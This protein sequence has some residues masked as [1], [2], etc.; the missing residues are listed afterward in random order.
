[1]FAETAASVRFRWLAIA[2]CAT[3]YALVVLGGVVRV[4]DSGDACPDWPRCHGELLPPLETDVLIEFSHRLLASVVG[5]LVVALAIA[6]WRTQRGPVVR[7][8]SLL[9]VGLVVVQIVLGGITVLSD[10]S[11]NMVMAHLAVA[12]AFFATLLVVALFSF[13]NPVRSAATGDMARFRTQAALASLA[14]LALMLTGSYVS[15]SG[16]GLAFR[17]WPLFDGGLLPDGAR[18]AV[19]HYAHRLAALLVGLYL[20]HVAVRA[21]RRHREQR[22]V[23]VLSTVIVALYGAQ[24]LV[25]AANIWTLLQPA[26]AGAHLALAVL[27][28]G[29]L[30]SMTV[31]AHRAALP[32]PAAAAQPARP[33]VEPARAAALAEPA[34]GQS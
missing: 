5:L 20:I 29:L 33:A 32:A 1:M 3:T 34:R 23:V 14:T 8:G 9:A 15:G 31:I 16:A 17:D 7:W 27:V 22:A 11:A 19:I 30:V 13:P 18:L 12:S 4:T 10:L 2:T 26:A 24:A 6:A 28:W 25:G 21:W